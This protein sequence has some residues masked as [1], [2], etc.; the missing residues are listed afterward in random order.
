MGC[1]QCS[2]NGNNYEDNNNKIPFNFMFPKIDSDLQKKNEE[3]NEKYIKLSREYD[4]L[5][6]NYNRSL[7][8]NK[9]T[10]NEDNRGGNGSST[11]SSI[12]EDDIEV[13]YKGEK[14]K[15]YI[16]KKKDTISKILSRFN[17]KYPEK[18][19]CKCIYKNKEVPLN[20]KYTDLDFQNDEILVLE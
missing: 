12:A 11:Q 17:Q 8:I 18:E 5:S 13:L 2:R 1:C 19:F 3:L 7:K 4:E 15:L 14:L 9:L 6:Q 20:K 16:K 10:Y